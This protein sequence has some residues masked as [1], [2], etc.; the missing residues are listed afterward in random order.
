MEIDYDDPTWDD[1]DE[2]CHGTMD[3]EENQEEHPE[4]FIWDCCDKGGTEPGC[5][6][7]HHYAI[8][9]KRMKT[10]TDGDSVSDGNDD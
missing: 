6:K 10:T 8:E 2:R 5:T 7:G 4:G 9:G 1:W 3:T